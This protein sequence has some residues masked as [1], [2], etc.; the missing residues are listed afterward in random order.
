MG[1]IKKHLI[2]CIVVVLCLLAC[3]AGAFLAFSASGKVSS[4]EQQVSSAQSQLNSLLNAAPAPTEANVD[5]SR[6]NVANLAGEL[7]AIREELQRGS[8]LQL[9]SD[10]VSVMAGIQQYISDYQRRAA[11]H[12]NAEGEPDPIEIEDDFAFGFEQYIDEAT[13]LDDAKR[14][15]RLDKQRQILS[16]LVNQLMASSPESIDAIGRELVEFPA[17]MQNEKD[18]FTISPA[19]SARVPGAIE[20]MAFS[21]SFRGYTTSLR[22]FLNNLAKFEL[23]IVVRSIEVERPSGSETVA[24]P[25]ANNNLD[26]IFGVFGGQDAAQEE[27]PQEAQQPVISENISRFTVVVEFIEIV[28]PD[29]SND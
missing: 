27:V 20:T 8:R 4:A 13:V 25:A 24:A 16:Y 29:E 28:L 1:F 11:A 15:P 6:E 21:L 2:F 23:P 9:S 17:N 26:S 12:T 5:A 22:S 18:G 3:G 14:I 7:K 10:G 19:I